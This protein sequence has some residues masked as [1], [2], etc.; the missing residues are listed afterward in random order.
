MRKSIV[1]CSYWL[2][3]RQCFWNIPTIHE[4]T[5]TLSEFPLCPGRIAHGSRSRFPYYFKRTD[6][7]SRFTL[8]IGN[9]TLRKYATHGILFGRKRDYPSFAPPTDFRN[10]VSFH[11]SRTY[12]CTPL[13]F[14]VCTCRPMGGNAVYCN[15]FPDIHRFSPAF[16]TGKG[17]QEISSYAPKVFPTYPQFFCSDTQNLLRKISRSII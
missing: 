8:H 5:H 1:C 9:N 15:D 14:F 13:W 16:G 11:H 4:T 7:W 12:V 6:T 2:L 17:E 3:L 10:R